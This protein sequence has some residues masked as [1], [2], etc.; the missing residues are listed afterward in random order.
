M[1]YVP[2][3]QS[4]TNHAK[5]FRLPRLLGEHRCLAVG[6]LVALWNWAADSALDGV[7]LDADADML[8][9]VMLY[10]GKPA[11][12]FDALLSAGFLDLGDDGSV[13]LHNWDLHMGPLIARREQQR[14]ASA[15]YRAKQK[16]QTL[17]PAQA[18]VDDHDTHGDDGHRGPHVDV[19]ITSTSRHVD[20]QHHVNTRVSR[21]EKNRLTTGI[22]TPVKSE[23]EKHARE[24]TADAVAHSQ[25]AD[26]QL[27]SPESRV[28]HVDADQRRAG[29][30]RSLDLEPLASSSSPATESPPTVKRQRAADPLWDACVAAIGHGPSNDIER[31]KWNKGLKALRQSL[32]TP[33]EITERCE[34]YRERFG[35]DIPLHPVVL[36]KNWTELAHEAHEAQEVNPYGTCT[37]DGR[38][39]RPQR[40][41]REI[42]ARRYG[43]SLLYARASV[44]LWSHFP[45]ACERAE[46]SAAT[47][48][49]MHNLANMAK[50]YFILR[51]A[52]LC[53]NS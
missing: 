32:A 51:L 8:A 6:R 25:T 47:C 16:D 42:A 48:D 40:P 14:Q 12:L 4:V 5:T 24:G 37:E 21:V 35:E 50:L 41:A 44:E 45:V 53:L 31:G 26:T 33:E 23:R 18:D 22:D 30:G 7:L 39:A 38:Y 9:S 27:Y 43:A 49:F 19:N 3:D 34:R 11:E 10:D 17:R 36:A 52:T 15:N 13:R 1:G 29:P 28:G 20:G 46:P 2:V